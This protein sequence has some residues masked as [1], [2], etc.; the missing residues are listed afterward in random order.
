[1]FLKSLEQALDVA[2]LGAARLFPKR[3]LR[4]PGQTWALPQREGDSE[5]VTPGS[6]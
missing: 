4:L 5:L 2:H 3:T 1:M 6:R